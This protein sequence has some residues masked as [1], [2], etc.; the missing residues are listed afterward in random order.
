MGSALQCL[1]WGVPTSYIFMLF[2]EFFWAAKSAHLISNGF[3]AVHFPYD[4][5]KCQSGNS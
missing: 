5:H 1:F 3:A 4:Y 2:R